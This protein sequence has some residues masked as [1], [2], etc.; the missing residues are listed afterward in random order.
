MTVFKHGKKKEHSIEINIVNEHQTDIG[1]QTKD[2]QKTYEGCLGAGSLELVIDGRKITHAIDHSFA[3]GSG[4]VVAYNTVSACSRRWFDFDVTPTN[5]IGASPIRGRGRRLSSD[6]NPSTLDI[7]SSV[8]NTM[9]DSGKCME[10][11]EERMEKDDIMSTAGTWSTIIIQTDVISLHVE[12]KQEQDRCSAHNLDVWV[13]SVTPEVAEEKW[14]GYIGETKKAGYKANGEHVRVERG[15]V[16]E[17]GEDEAY[18]V[19]SPFSTKCKGCYK[20]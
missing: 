9:I 17:Y 2:G 13:S 19:Q 11:M 10:W 1:C 8:K 15:E 4:R 5:E 12:Y 20:H 3:D 18:E 6:T 7:L 16:L 14:E